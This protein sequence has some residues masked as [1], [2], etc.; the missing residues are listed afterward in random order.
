MRKWFC[1]FPTYCMTKHS[2]TIDEAQ[3]TADSIG[4]QWDTVRF[5]L[6]QFRMGMDIEQEHGTRNPQTNVTD[7]DVLT[8]GKIALAHLREY[9]DYYT[10]LATMESEAEAYWKQKE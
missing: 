10:R 8:T 5:D 6:E 9:P 1:L 7:D 4:I 2:F 3:K